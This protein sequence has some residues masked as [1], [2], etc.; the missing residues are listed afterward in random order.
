MVLMTY[1]QKLFCSPPLQ[2][3]SAES[4]RLLHGDEKN[5]QCREFN[6]LKRDGCVK[7]YTLQRHKKG[8]G[9]QS[10]TKKGTVLIIV[11]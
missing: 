1:L 4:R 7:D 6:V 8:D 10:K 11:N 3:L 5:H 9:F 2:I